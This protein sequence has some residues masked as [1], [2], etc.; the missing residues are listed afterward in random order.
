MR[1]GNSRNYFQK[2]FARASGHC[3]RLLSWSYPNARYLKVLNL[4]QVAQRKEK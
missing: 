3:G 1:P 2:R 4:M